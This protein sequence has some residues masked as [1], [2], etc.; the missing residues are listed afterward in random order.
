MKVSKGILKEIVKYEK[1]FKKSAR[2][3][4]LFSHLSSKKERRLALLYGLMVCEKQSAKKAIELL[5]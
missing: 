4:K 5:L 3:V 1:I 2:N